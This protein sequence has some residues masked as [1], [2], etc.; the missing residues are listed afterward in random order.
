MYVCTHFIALEFKPN[1]KLVTIYAFRVV[2]TDP[3]KQER[4]QSA[5]AKEYLS[6]VWKGCSYRSCNVASVATV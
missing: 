5:W 4:T 2:T 1:A 3:N 6:G